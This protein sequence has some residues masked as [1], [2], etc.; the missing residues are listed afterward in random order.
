VSRESVGIGLRDI[1]GARDR[2][3]DAVVRTPTVP[4]LALGDRIPAPLHL[5]LESQQR[6]GSFKD[7]GALNRLLALSDAERRGGVVI[8]QPF[9]RPEILTIF[10]RRDGSQHG[11]LAQSASSARRPTGEARS[12]TTHWR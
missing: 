6:T 7:R 12:I 9:E 1:E 8:R 3:A 11:A 10:E 4:A 5:K 2:I